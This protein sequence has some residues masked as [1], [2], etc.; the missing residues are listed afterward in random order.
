MSKGKGDITKKPVEITL[1]ED[2]T[3]CFL[4][5]DLAKEAFGAN[6]EKLREKALGNSSDSTT[7]DASITECASA[8]PYLDLGVAGAEV[9]AVIAGAVDQLD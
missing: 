8:N 3:V 9:L 4:P 7:S 2:L 6:F 1:P 5:D